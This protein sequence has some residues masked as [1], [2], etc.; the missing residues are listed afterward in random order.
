MGISKTN[1][2]LSTILLF[3][4]IVGYPLVTTLFLPSF[5]GFY[6]GAGGDV[7]IS[8]VIT[9]PYRAIVLGISISVILMNWKQ[10]VSMTFPMKVYLVFWFFLSL[11]IVYDLLIRTDIIIDPSVVQNQ[12]LY[13]Y[14]V[15]LI[16]AIALYKGLKP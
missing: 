5:T 15:C 11:R 9:V 16:P 6:D 8:R 13:T 2:F 10:Y 7:T 12:F 14:A 4:T 3:L 1:R